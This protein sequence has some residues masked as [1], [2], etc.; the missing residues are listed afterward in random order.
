VLA[1]LAV[2]LIVVPFAELYVIIQVSH[3]LG[4]GVTLVL[5]L[6]VSLAGAWLVKQEGFGVLRRAQARLDA[7]RLPG[8]ELIDGILILCAGALLLAPGFITDA[9]GILLLLPPVRAGIR[10]LV[11][12]YLAK[13]VVGL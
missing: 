7:G 9:L 3:H 13:R 11:V 12:R 5:L 2:L 6:A 8:N 1:L 10:I 4:L